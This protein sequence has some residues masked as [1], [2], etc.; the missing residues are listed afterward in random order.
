MKNCHTSQICAPTLDVLPQ[1]LVMMTLYLTSDPEHN[2]FHF[3]GPYG[4]FDT[5]LLIIY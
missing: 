1:I 2:L 3:T 4:P 5:I